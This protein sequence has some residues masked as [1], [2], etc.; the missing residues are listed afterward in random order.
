MIDF[1]LS[2]PQFEG[3]VSFKYDAEGCLKAFE[4][5]AQLN[6]DQT[7]WLLT[8]LPKTIAD[9]DA[10]RKKKMTATI[11]QVKKEITFDMLWHAYGYKE[12]KQEAMNVWKKLTAREQQEAYDYIPRYKAK[13][14]LNGVARKYPK[15]YLRQKPWIS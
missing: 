10:L 13:L 9:M 15:T 3:E 7:I 4:N 8:N 11:K 2:S 5:N 1:V 12:D 14:A 6:E